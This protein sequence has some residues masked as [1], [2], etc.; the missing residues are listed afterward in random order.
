MEQTQTTVYGVFVSNWQGKYVIGLTG[1]IATGKS[2][3]RRMLEH[4]GAYTI[5]ADMLAHRV[6]A[7][8]APGYKPVLD[9]FGVWLLDKDGQI[10]RAK[11]GRLV[12]ADE[13]ALAQLEAI[14]HPH[15]S[16]AIDLLVRRSG[17]NVIVIE[18][19]KLLESDLRGKCDSI[20]VTDADREVRVERL[21]RKRGMTREDALQRL[22]AQSAPEA[23][24]AAANVVI[25]NNGS[26]EDLWR[27]VNDAWK[28]LLPSA[29]AE[30]APPIVSRPGPGPEAFSLQRGKPRD[31]QKIAE[32]ITRLSRGKRAMTSEDVMEAFGDKAFLLLQMGNDLVGV[33]GWQVENLVARTLDLYLDPK[34]PP[35]KALPLLLDEVERASAELQCEASLVFPPMELV[36]FD[37]IWKRAGYERRAADS[38]GVQAWME[39]ANESMPKGSALFFKQLRAD[40]VLRP[41]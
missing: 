10:N 21:V 26:Y 38:L 8:G 4:L 17:Q 22:N 34:A 40:R 30:P 2:V 35:E 31:S 23:K 28:R 9:T 18:A 3:V 24:I 5:D 37:A 20:W 36:G 11:L 32:L 29:E 39:A 1:N 6:I 27:Q 12:F 15:V 13:Q 7:K 25:K 16:Q 33:A 19:I 14:I 41:I